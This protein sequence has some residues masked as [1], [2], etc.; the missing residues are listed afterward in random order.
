[1]IIKRNVVQYEG[2]ETTDRRD[3]VEIT[4]MEFD[5]KYFKIKFIQPK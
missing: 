1:M 3:L 2:I 5:R 4:P